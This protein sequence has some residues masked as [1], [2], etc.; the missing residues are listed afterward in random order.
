[1]GILIFGVTEAVQLIAREHFW[2][3]HLMVVPPLVAYKY[4][5]YHRIG[6]HYFLLD[7]CYLVNTLILGIIFL[8]PNSC[9][10]FGICFLA[11]FGPMGLSIKIY[12][13]SIVFHDVDRISSFFIHLFPMIMMYNMRFPPENA[14]IAFQHCTLD[15]RDYGNYML[16]W[17]FWVILY[18]YVL[19]VRHGEKI[20]NNPSLLTNIRY[21]AR[22]KTN[23]TN[24]ICMKLCR[25]LNI[26]GKDDVFD[27]ETKK[28]KIIFTLAHGA[29]IFTSTVFAPI[30]HWSQVMCVVFISAMCLSAL[31]Q[32]ASFYIDYF[33]ANYREKFKAR[34]DDGGEW[35]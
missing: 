15:L 31:F 35:R 18:F 32:G 26:M 33:S 5:Y 14:T 17:L 16:F 4:V 20:V 34:F 30:C 28:T 21:I 9:D 6:F 29:F 7:Y 23:P 13:N 3:W 8:F 19:E 25:A 22:A 11:T 12:R 24:V 27:P 1:M 2:I 10:A